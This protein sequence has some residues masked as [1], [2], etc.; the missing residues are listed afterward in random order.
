MENVIG[1][2]IVGGILIYNFVKNY[3]KEIK[4]NQERPNVPIPPVES[5]DTPV[6]PFAKRKEKR[7]LEYAFQE[8]YV[9]T[10]NVAP[11]YATVNMSAME[12]EMVREEL[13]D[14]EN[15]DEETIKSYL[16]LDTPA[17]T[18]RA[19]VHSLIFERKY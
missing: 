4:K 7:K 11:A 17:D 3:K 18:R 1:F 9:E 5:Q 8:E 19:F 6:R 14:M 2:L 12:E 13:A 16:D 15:Q 10:Q